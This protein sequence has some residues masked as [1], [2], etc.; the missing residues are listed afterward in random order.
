MNHNKLG[1]VCA[2]KA[3]GLTRS[4]AAELIDLA[5]CLDNAA[6]FLVSAHF[7]ANK[8]YE[9]F[10]ATYIASYYFV[11]RKRR[12]DINQSKKCLLTCLLTS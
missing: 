7:A 1:I 12:Q 8:Q 11:C 2:K 3:T 4:S 10:F 5:F 9:V 6:E